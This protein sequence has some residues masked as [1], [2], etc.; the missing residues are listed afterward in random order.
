MCKAS[1]FRTIY[2][3]LFFVIMECV[4]CCGYEGQV[5]PL[6]VLYWNDVVECANRWLEYNQPL[7]ML[8]VASKNR[9]LW[10]V[11]CEDL[12]KTYGY[13]SKCR[14]SFTNKNK[15]DA[16]KKLHDKS[17]LQPTTDEQETVENI[18]TQSPAKTRSRTAS[19]SVKS[20]IG[21]LEKRCIIC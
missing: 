14:T 15:L 10:S 11:P 5:L 4:C 21:T 8:T 19:F 7:K 13:H 12:N 17:Q 20:S 3:F 6:T 9:D 1:L 18:P 2:T 16:T